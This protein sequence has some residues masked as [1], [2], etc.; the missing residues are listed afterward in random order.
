MQVDLSGP[1]GNAYALMALVTNTAR[2][3]R[4]GVE[5]TQNVVTRMSAG[6]YEEMLDVIDDE[7]SGVFDFL[8]DPRPNPPTLSPE[9]RTMSRAASKET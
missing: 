7:F 8:A 6:T 3:L 1:Q 9:L 5:M 4:L 2:H